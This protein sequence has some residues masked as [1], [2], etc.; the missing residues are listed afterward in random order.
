MSARWASLKLLEGDENLLT[1]IRS[2][3]CDLTEDEDLAALAVRA[4][5]ELERAGI[6]PN[7][8]TD[9]VVTGIIGK[10]ELV[11]GEAVTFKKEVLGYRP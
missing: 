5:S 1:A 6:G 2:T 11:A 4:R 9:A 10:C 8:L 7:E 3:G